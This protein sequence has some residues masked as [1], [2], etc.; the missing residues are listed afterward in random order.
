MPPKQTLAQK[1]SANNKTELIPVKRCYQCQERLEKK[2][3]EY[4]DKSVGKAF[5]G[6]LY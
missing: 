1:R 4:K 3:F 5:L 2:Y 6:C